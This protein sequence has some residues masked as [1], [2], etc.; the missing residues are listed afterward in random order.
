VEDLDYVGKLGSRFVS[1]D[2]LE[3]ADI[4]DGSIRRPT[5]VNANLTHT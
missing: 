4:G 3:E 1:M 2:E 5:Y